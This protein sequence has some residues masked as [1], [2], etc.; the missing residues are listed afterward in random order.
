[1]TAPVHEQISR[2]ERQ[3]TAPIQTSGSGSFTASTSSPLHSSGG[4]VSTAD[5]IRNK[6]RELLRQRDID[7]MLMKQRE[8]ELELKVTKAINV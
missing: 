1:V 2:L 8:K 7:M 3:V 4:N 5:Q 6:L